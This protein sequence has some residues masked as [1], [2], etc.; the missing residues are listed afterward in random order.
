VVAVAEDTPVE[1][2]DITAEQMVAVVV[3]VLSMEERI[4]ST[5]V[6]SVRVMV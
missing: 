5:L 3:E 6:V 4:L 2:V 1:L